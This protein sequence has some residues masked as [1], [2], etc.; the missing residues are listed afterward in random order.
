MHGFNQHVFLTACCTFAKKRQLTLPVICSYPSRPNR[1]AGAS[2]TTAGLLRNT[3]S[4]ADICLEQA[5]GHG[6]A[7]NQS[8]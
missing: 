8:I 4:W 6:L 5:S 3:D 7:A 1:S 2:E